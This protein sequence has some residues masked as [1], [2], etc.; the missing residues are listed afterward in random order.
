MRIRSA[1]LLATVAFLF[2]ACGDDDDAIDTSAG[3]DAGATQ[4]AGSGGDFDDTPDAAADC[5]DGADCD[6]TGGGTDTGG[7]DEGAAVRAA[8]ALVGTPERELDADVRVSRRGDEQFMLTED[9]VIGRM[10]VELD[11]R[12]SGFVVTKVVLELTEGPM[13]FT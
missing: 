2:A 3:N 7:I 12:G 4:L 11:D 6:D 13:T 8:E 10:T 9:Y 1:V 5:I